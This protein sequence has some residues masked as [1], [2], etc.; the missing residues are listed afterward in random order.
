MKR[1][2]TFAVIAAMLLFAAGASAQSFR[3]GYFLDNYVYGYRINPAQINRK[4]FFA[5]GVGN[6]DLQN[7]L[8]VGVSNFLFPLEDGRMVTGFNKDVPAEQFIG[9]LPKSTLLSLDENINLFSSGRVRNNRMTTF[10]VNVRALSN[11]ALPRDLFA[12]LKQGGDTPYD[13]SGINLSAAVLGDAALGF[14]TRVGKHLSIGTRLHFLVN[15]ADLRA[16]ST[17]TSI[18]MG[19][20]QTELQ[21]ELHLQ[22]S[23]MLSLATNEKGNLDFSKASYKGP[24]F[25]SY[26]AGLDLGF[27]LNS[28]RGFK[29]FGSVTEL[30]AIKRKNTTNLVANSTV[31]YTGMDVTYED[32]DVNADYQAILDKLQDAIIFTDAQTGDRL[33]ILPF[34]A[35]AGA[36]LTLL[37]FI[38]VG[39]LGTYHIDSINPWYDL[40][41]G[42][43]VALGYFLSVSANA[44]IGTYGPTLGAGFNLNF[45]GLNLVAGVDAFRGNVGTLSGLPVQL[46]V[47]I[48]LP[49][50]GFNLNAHA[51]LS[52]NFGKSYK[53]EYVSKKSTKEV[54]EVKPEKSTTKSSTVKKSPRPVTPRAVPKTTPKPTVSTRQER[55]EQ[56]KKI[57]ELKKAQEARKAA[58]QQ[59]TVVE[60]VVPA[61]PETVVEQIL[62]EVVAPV[63]PETPAE[64][65]AE[66]PAE[67]PAAPAEP[68]PAE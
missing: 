39:A 64:K 52:V 14:A 28:G 16:Y 10:E 63:E 38:S 18:T 48:P 26:G 20:N 54:K 42:A 5:L 56:R 9:N 41:A 23:G 19:A 46:P 8:N 30:G 62:E 1:I 58:E 55:E 29:L 3:S 44:G 66:E 21:S 60:P 37:N 45:L 61:E 43:S 25:S 2:N 31:T 67:Q 49:L 24:I 34:N 35:T 17:N 50:T 53:D 51:G 6:I 7:S 11:M 68:A 57:E 27:E 65:P 13:L 32:G 15:V 33:D 59:Q 47:A 12:F 22:T 4:S 40:R 36:R